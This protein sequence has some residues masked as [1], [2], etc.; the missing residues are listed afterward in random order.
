M[1]LM[2]ELVEPPKGSKPGDRVFI[3]GYEDGKPESILPPKKKIFETI[4]PGYLTNDNRVAGWVDADKKSSID[5]LSMVGNA[6]L[7]LSLLAP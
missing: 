7:P 6:S 2:L 1:A 4:Q 3:E 5:S